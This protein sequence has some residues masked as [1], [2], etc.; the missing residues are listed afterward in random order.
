M[1]GRLPLALALPRGRDDVD[2][3]RLAGVLLRRG[4]GCM[5]GL[6]SCWAPLVRS[7]QADTTPCSPRAA[8]SPVKVLLVD[9]VPLATAAMVDAPVPGG[10]TRA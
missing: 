5:S 7:N 2:L 1:G 10:M 6:G 4:L 3:A 8:M 9:S